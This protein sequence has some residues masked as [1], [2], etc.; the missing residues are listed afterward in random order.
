MCSVGDLEMPKLVKDP[1]IVKGYETSLS[2]LF[3]CLLYETNRFHVSMR[4]LS[5]RRQKMSP[6]QY[7]VRISA[8]QSPAACV[9]LFRN[10]GC[11]AG[12]FEAGLR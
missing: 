11:R 4:L 5:N 10:M 7:V 1:R 3:S 6:S 2:F 8:T 9:P 12:L